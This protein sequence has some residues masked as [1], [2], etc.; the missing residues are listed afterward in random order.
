MQSY[1]LPRYTTLSGFDFQ[2]CGDGIIILLFY[3]KHCFYIHNIGR[4]SILSLLKEF[5]VRMRENI[6]DIRSCVYSVNI[7]QYT[8]IMSFWEHCF[9]WNPGF[10]R[11]LEIS[12][13]PADI[14][15]GPD[16]RHS[17]QS[18]TQISAGIPLKCQVSTKIFGFCLTMT[19]LV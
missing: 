18:A 2:R 1:L 19:K 10:V 12:V 16:H 5:A 17:V 4:S 9:Y 8:N 11:V 15:A 7:R 6:N 3:M 13:I 14:W